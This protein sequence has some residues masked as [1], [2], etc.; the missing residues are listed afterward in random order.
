MRSRNTG[1]FLLFLFSITTVFAQKQ[2]IELSY[3]VRGDKSVAFS[4]KKNE[5]GSYFLRIDFPQLRNAHQSSYEQ[6]IKYDHGKL[7]QLRPIHR[8][9]GIQFSYKYSFIRGI[10]NPDVDSLFQYALPVQD[11]KA[12][13]IREASHVG[14]KYFSAE[15][16]INWTSYILY[17]NKPE[18]VH[19]MRRGL[20][21]EVLDQFDANTDKDK[22]F[23]S[24][25]NHVII[26]H[27][28]GTYAMYKGLNKGTI[29]V[30]PG[31]E[32]FP[33]NLLGEMQEFNKLLYRLDFSVYYLYNEEFDDNKAKSLREEKS[34]NKYLKPYFIT[35][36]GVIQ[37]ESGK[38]YLPEMNAAIFTRE[39]SNRE[40][41]QYGKD[42]EAFK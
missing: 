29:A 2:P 35:K 5:P 1:I 10:P 8:E 30:E 34:N 17:A 24:D 38:E 28:D 19:S 27:E 37:I 26:E 39:F 41:R 3:E 13:E 16:P 14:E 20:V 32:V 40:K 21:V 9:E 15:R 31:D 18:T 25:R 11:T 6:V 33:G 7:L 22:T 23:T 42:P 12:V 36:S 4:Y